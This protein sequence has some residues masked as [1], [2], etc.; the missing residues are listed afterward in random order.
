[1]NLV[2]TKRYLINIE[3][4][5]PFCTASGGAMPLTVLL[6]CQSRGCTVGHSESHA[7]APGLGYSFHQISKSPWEQTQFSTA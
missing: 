1:M 2:L 5:K 3:G 4:K 6:S 7:E